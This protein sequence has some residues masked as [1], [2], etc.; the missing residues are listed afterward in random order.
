MAEASNASIEYLGFS[1]LSAGIFRGGR[2]LSDVLRV[3]MDAIAAHVYP[4]LKEVH[5]VGFQEQ[6]KKVLC[7]CLQERK[8]RHGNESKR[9]REEQSQ[10]APPSH[11]A[12]TPKSAAPRQS[13][14]KLNRGSPKKA[15]RQD[16]EEA[17]KKKAAAAKSFAYTDSAPAQDP[18]QAQKQKPAAAQPSPYVDAATG[19]INTS[20]AAPAAPS[21]PSSQQKRPQP[22]A[23]TESDAPPPK[24]AKTSPAPKSKPSQKPKQPKGRAKLAK[25]ANAK[26]QMS[27]GFAAAVKPGGKAEL[28]AINQRPKDAGGGSE[29]GSGQASAAESMQQLLVRRVIVAG[30]WVAFFQEYQQ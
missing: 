20:P 22:V 15:A 1:L 11:A 24:K 29:A 8:E 27:L 30:V 10:A 13:K 5:M 3:G 26:G 14:M 4:G 6:E 16:P 25:A 28:V 18:E 21:R 17:E 7:R 23:K 9:Q 2:A 19:Y 12:K